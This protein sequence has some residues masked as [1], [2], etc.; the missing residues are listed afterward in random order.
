MTATESASLR[1]VW[2]LRLGGVVTAVAVVIVAMETSMMPAKLHVPLEAGSALVAREHSCSQMASFDVGDE[3]RLAREACAADVAE[4]FARDFRLVGYRAGQ[5]GQRPSLIGRS[6]AA[7]S[8]L[9]IQTNTMALDR[10]ELKHASK[11]QDTPVGSNI[12][13]DPVLDS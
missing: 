7:S 11:I 3:R 4:E 13:G 9:Q 10:T 12:T 8:R 5:A 1:F 2:R 6:R